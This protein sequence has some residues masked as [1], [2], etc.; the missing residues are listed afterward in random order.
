VTRLGSEETPGRIHDALAA[1][2]RV[3]KNPVYTS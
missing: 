1:A 3:L 2:G